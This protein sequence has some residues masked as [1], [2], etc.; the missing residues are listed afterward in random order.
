MSGRP[1][2]EALYW[3]EAGAALRALV[4]LAVVPLAAGAA[5]LTLNGAGARLDPVRAP[6]AATSGCDSCR[7][8]PLPTAH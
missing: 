4:A 1:S 6:P 5:A 7:L 8:Q 2:L 3:Q